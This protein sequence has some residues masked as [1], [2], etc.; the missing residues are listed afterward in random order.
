MSST[1]APS[2]PPWLPPWSPLWPPPWLAESGEYGSAHPADLFSMMHHLPGISWQI[3]LTYQWHYILHHT[4]DTFSWPWRSGEYNT[5]ITLHF[6]YHISHII[7]PTSY[8]FEILKVWGLLY[9]D[10]WVSLRCLIGYLWV[11]LALSMAVYLGCLWGVSW[12]SLGFATASFGCPWVVSSC[13]LGVS[14]VP[15]RCLHCISGESL[16]VSLGY[17]LG[18]YRCAIGVLQQTTNFN[19]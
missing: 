1:R 5:V 14:G 12:V 18:C 3:T 15:L 11:S 19:R 16:G 13:F 9:S 10:S 8:F 4:Y 7:H 6:T 2:L 17:V